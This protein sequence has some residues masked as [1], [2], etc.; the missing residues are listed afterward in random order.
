MTMASYR[1]D[2]LE[3]DGPLD[4]YEVGVLRDWLKVLREDVEAFGAT[5]E[6]EARMARIEARIRPCGGAGQAAS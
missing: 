6:D 5:P 3:R 2:L 4:A 1:N